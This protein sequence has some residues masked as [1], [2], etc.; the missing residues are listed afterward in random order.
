MSIEGRASV[1]CGFPPKLSQQRL[2]STRWC[3]LCFGVL[4]GPVLTV[5]R[6]YGL[7]TERQDWRASMASWQKG[8][9]HLARNG[10]IELDASSGNEFQIRLGTRAKRA[11][12]GTA[13]K[14]R[15]AA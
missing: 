7:V 11:M 8:L 5:S 13:G 6:S 9:Q 3:P 14:T 2:S 1:R 4:I 15:A 12:R 10:W